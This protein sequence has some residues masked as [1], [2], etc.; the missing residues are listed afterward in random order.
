MRNKITQ[1]ITMKLMD[2]TKKLNEHIVSLKKELELLDT[3]AKKK[4]N[5]AESL[6]E[7]INSQENQLVILEKGIDEITILD[8]N[9]YEYQ[10]SILHLLSL[11]IVNFGNHFKQ[12][13]SS[14][15]KSQQKIEDINKE[16]DDKHTKIVAETEVLLRN[17]NDLDIYRK[18][19]EKKCAELYPEIKIII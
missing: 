6:Q 5:I 15:N 13:E 9:L 11:S 7:R 16:Y 12:I 8:N 2:E 18:R 10:S 1:T 3:E 19:L 4:F 17:K 14:I